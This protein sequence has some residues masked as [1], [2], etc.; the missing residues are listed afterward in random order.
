LKLKPALIPYLGKSV[1]LLLASI[2]LLVLG[3]SDTLEFILS[4][5]APFP[6][7][8]IPDIV[9]AICSILSLAG[10]VTAIIAAISFITAQVYRNANT[11]LLTRDRIIIRRSLISS[12]RREIPYS[13]ISDVTIDQTLLGRIF[14][15]G[16][17]IPISISGFGIIEQERYPSEKRLD[18]LDSVAKPRDVSQ[19]ILKHMQA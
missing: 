19:R 15:Y 18:Q 16:D 12:I 4:T 17:V 13:K 3:R 10:V 8:S 1:G 14:G 11:Y 5:I 9:T 7:K 2:A 6:V